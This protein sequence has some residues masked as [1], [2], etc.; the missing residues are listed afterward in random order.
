MYMYFCIIYVYIY[1]HIHILCRIYYILYT[2]TCR[3]LMFMWSFRAGDSG[4]KS[5]VWQGLLWQTSAGASR[6]QRGPI[7][8]GNRRIP[9]SG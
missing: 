7:E 6:Q 2:M 3:I 1:M 4:S 8:R 9:H 5:T